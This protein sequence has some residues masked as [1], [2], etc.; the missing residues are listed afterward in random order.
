MPIP[1]NRKAYQQ[2]IDENLDWLDRQPRSCEREH[3]RQIVRQSPEREFN[4]K[5]KIQSLTQECDQLTRE[6]SA[7]NTQLNVL[8]SYRDKNAYLKA[9]VDLCGAL[10]MQYSYLIN[11]L[12][13]TTEENTTP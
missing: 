8:D 10:V 13:R 4:D 9:L 7:L 11:E 3:I 6:I 2:L 1:L 12:K 5:D